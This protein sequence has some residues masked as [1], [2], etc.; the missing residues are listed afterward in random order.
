VAGSAGSNGGAGF[1]GS[2]PTAGSGGSAGSAGAAGAAGNAGSAG[3]SGGAG[4][5]LATCV[6]AGNELCDDFES[7]QLDPSKWQTN[8]TQ[9]AAVTVDTLHA[10]SGKYAVHIH[11]TAGQQTTAQITEAVTFPAKNDAF[12]TRIFAYFSPDL[13]IEA[14]ADFHTG[15]IVASGKNDLG[16][17]RA[18]LGLIGGDQQ[19]LGYSIFFGP[20]KHEFGPWSQTRVKPNQWLC[21]ELFES[22]ADGT[23]ETRQIWVDGQ[24]LTELK[25]TYNGQ[26]P[27]AWTLVSIGLE[28]YHPIPTL[29]DMWIDDVRVS[30][31]PIG[32]E[33]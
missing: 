7:A 29:S 2:S 20:P 19:F 17:V 26:K 28:E 23:S 4:G 8:P 25:S 22:G 31:Q 1:G 33:R 15:F 18:G 3:A 24:E 11:V 30:S 6:T 9:S 5:A 12:Y 10:H 27:P 21:L 14:G 13:P 16:A 32:C